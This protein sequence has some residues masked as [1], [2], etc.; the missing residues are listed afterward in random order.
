[1]MPNN[2]EVIDR[3]AAEYVLGTLR[4]S[5]RRRFERWRET[6]P[7]VDQRCRFWE[8]RLLELAADLKPMRPPTYVWLA[9]ERRLNFPARR[10]LVQR[11]RRF[12]LLASLVLLACATALLYW[13]SIPIIRP[14]SEATISARSGERL[15]ELEVF[16]KADRIGLHA[17]KRP[18]RQAKSDYELWA[19]PTG[20]APVSL[21]ILPAEGEL[22][23]ALTVI[24]KQALTHS[25]QL[26]VTIEP[27]GGSPTGQPT[28][29][30]LYVAPLRSAF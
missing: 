1:M 18:T 25:S 22:M 6:I 23:R 10:S 9:I 2:G 3:V 16:G 12:P 7:V 28:G 27:L 4:G 13:R 19:L 14:T 17:A 5:P 8:E 26:A 30:I 11:V 24:Q 15:W 21:G 20:A 29:A